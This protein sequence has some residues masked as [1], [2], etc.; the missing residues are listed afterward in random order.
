MSETVKDI[1][2]YPLEKDFR[3]K[4]GLPAD[5]GPGAL[6]VADG[7]GEDTWAKKEFGGAPL[8]DKRLS[9][10]LVICADA[11]AKKPDRPFS[12]VAQGDWPALT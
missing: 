7:L 2:L 6:Q 9:R 10:R 4:L 3:L 5:S 11:K 12:G 8:G 1:Y